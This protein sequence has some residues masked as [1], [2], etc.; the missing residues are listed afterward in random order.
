M[1]KIMMADQKNP[2]IIFWRYILGPITFE[3]QYTL[4]NRLFFPS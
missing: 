3:R 2:N 1:A 4:Y